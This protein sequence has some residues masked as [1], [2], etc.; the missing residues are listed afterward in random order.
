MVL[1]QILLRTPTLH[2]IINC[3][4]H[5]TLNYLLLIL[6]FACVM[7][8][9]LKPTPTQIDSLN[10]EVK[11]IY[12]YLNTDLSDNCDYID[13]DEVRDVQITKKDLSIVQWN[14][15]GLLSS[16]LEVAKLLNYSNRR[17]IDLIILAETWLS[18]TSEKKLRLNGYEY[19]GQTRK[20]KKGGGVG[21]IIN[22]SL[23]YKVRPDIFLDKENFE[24]VSI[25]I[26][27][28]IASIIVSSI[29]RP[30]NTNQQ[31]FVDNLVRLYN[32][33][34][35]EKGKE[36]IIGL[37][38]NMDLLKYELNKNTQLFMEKLL[39]M[40]LYP[41]I[42]RPTRITKSCAT[43]IDNIIMNKTLYSKQNSCIIINDTSDHLPCLSVLHDVSFGKDEQILITE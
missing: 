11:D 20:N 10:Q 37:D 40:E 1:H 16:E 31:N 19:F 17:K 18:K 25:E 42:T 13:E 15:R 7:C 28:G 24:N 33:I 27:T 2:F 8:C 6:H 9:L 38:H 43:L 3:I 5:L 21:I 32:L 39:E 34:Q 36:W 23:K 29:Y 30:P 26:K 12:T 14:I 41:T 22:K 4:H 35:K